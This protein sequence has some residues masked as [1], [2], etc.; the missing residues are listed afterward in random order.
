MQSKY[1]VYSHFMLL[2]FLPFIALNPFDMLSGRVLYS[3]DYTGVGKK[4]CQ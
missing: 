3:A 2:Y 4:N 1:M